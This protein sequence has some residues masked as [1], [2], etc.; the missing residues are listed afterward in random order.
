MK[1]ISGKNLTETLD[2]LKYILSLRGLLRLLHLTETLD[3]LKSKVMEA[4]KA[5][6]EDLT[7]TLDVLKFGN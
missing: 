7:E 2:V 3:V 4:L 5:L 1:S 6:K